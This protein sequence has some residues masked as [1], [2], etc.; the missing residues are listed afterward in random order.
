MWFCFYSDVTL[1]VS[2]PDTKWASKFTSVSHNSNVEKH[3]TLWN[4]FHLYPAKNIRSDKPVTKQFTVIKLFCITHAV[5]VNKLSWNN[6]KVSRVIVV[7]GD[8]RLRNC[9]LAPCV[10]SQKVYRMS[11]FGS[12]SRSK[13]KKRKKKGICWMNAPF[14]LCLNCVWL[15][16]ADSRLCFIPVV[17]APLLSSC[18]LQQSVWKM[19]T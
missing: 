15:H 10:Q 1:P 12:R 8:I 5:N 4:G 6:V 11:N 14:P 9:R 3:C 18:L 17:S 7:F 2:S 19:H 16:S 13:K